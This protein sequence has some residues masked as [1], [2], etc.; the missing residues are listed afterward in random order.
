[1]KAPD[2]YLPLPPASF[3]ILLSLGSQDRHG[4]AIMK[5]VAE[6]TND[7]V[8][9]SP[10]T[11]YIAIKRLLADDL[12]EELE[13][14]PD[15]EVD[16]ERRRYYRLTRLGRKVAEAELARLRSLIRG[17]ARALQSES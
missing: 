11:L 1:M 4:Y 12:I 16:D 3:Q 6:R 13:E 14:R 17:A 5:E 2:E 15:P 7:Q 10:G 8:R 9:L